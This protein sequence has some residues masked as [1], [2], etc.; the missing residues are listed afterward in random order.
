MAN[1]KILDNAVDLGLGLI[2]NHV[3]K[4]VNTINKLSNV[5]TVVDGIKKHNVHSK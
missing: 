4:T 1:S 5:L 2:T 3:T